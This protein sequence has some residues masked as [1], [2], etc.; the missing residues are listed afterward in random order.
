MEDG[1][2]ST[3]LFPLFDTY[4]KHMHRLAAKPA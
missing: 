3:P 2:C 4:S 1:R